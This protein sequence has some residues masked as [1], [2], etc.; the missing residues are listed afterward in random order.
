VGRVVLRATIPSVPQQIVYRWA[1]RALASAAAVFAL[2]AQTVGD[3]ANG[4][5]I[6]EGK[7]NCTGCHC[8]KGNGSHFGPDLS[9]VGARSPAQLETSIVD[10]D[11]EIAPANR[12]VRVVL[13]NGATTVGRLL[14]EDTFSVQVIDKTERLLSFQKAD[15]KEYAFETKSPMPSFKDKLSAQE[16]A[17]VVAYLGSLKP[18][19]GTGR[20]G[21]GAPAA[22]PPPPV[23]H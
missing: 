21:R 13:K 4:K 9:E 19:P 3:T 23:A 12:M 5:L 17:D 18:P 8:I 6:F 15:V 22:A 7:G 14:N 10:P 2:Q 11:A 16:L 20:G 1:I